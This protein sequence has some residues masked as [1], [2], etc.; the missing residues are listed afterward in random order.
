MKHYMKYLPLLLS[1]LFFASCGSS[2]STGGTT[3][4]G[5]SQQNQYLGTNSFNN[6]QNGALNFFVFGNGTASG[7][8]GV[9]NDVNP[10]ATFA[11]GNYPITGTASLASGIFSLTGEIPGVGPFTVSG[12]IP[13]NGAQATYTV[14]INNQTF[15]GTVQSAAQGFPPVNGGNNGGNGTLIS[16]GTINN[17][18]F[19]LSNDFNGDNPPIGTDATISGAFGE[20]QNGEESLTI[21]LTQTVSVGPPLQINL[22]TVSII[23]PNGADLVLN[24]PYQ[25]VVNTT[26]AGS[27]ATL[28]EV[29]NS[30]ATASWVSVGQTSSGTATITALSDTSVTLE[31]NFDN[32]VVNPEVEGNT[33]T[34]SFD[35]IGSVTGNFV[36]T[37]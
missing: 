20:G 4:G 32:L 5:I 10:Q 12:T 15:Q 31:F 9:A 30:N 21:S 3:G 26:D 2:N 24:Q 33:A 36:T 29:E 17:L 1:L 18:Q 14:T 35:L 6:G 23:D 19:Q 27:L 37:P 8:F 22:L 7:E 11:V 16:G 13:Q 25:V 28:S 34:G